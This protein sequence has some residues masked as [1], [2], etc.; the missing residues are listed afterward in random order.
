M[1][2]IFKK[3]ISTILIFEAKLVLKK[4]KPKIV[5]VT[6]SVG[7]TSTKDA[8]FAVLA[9]FKYVRKSEKSFNS[10]IGLP[11]TILGLE[12][13]WSNPFKWIRNILDGISLIV[14]KTDYPEWLVLEVGADRPGDI[15]KISEWLKSDIAVFTKF[16]KVPVHVEFFPTPKDVVEEKANL[17]RGLKKDG[18]LILNGDDEDATS[19]LERSKNHTLIYKVD[20]SADVSASNYKINYQEKNGIKSPIGISFKVEYKGNIVPVSIDGVLGRQQ[21]YPVLAGLTVAVAEDLNFVQAVE[22]LKN[23]E[24]PKGRMRIIEGIN[25]STIIDDTYNS[26]PV[27][28]NEAIFTLKSLEINSGSKKVAVLGDMM[29]LGKYSADEHKKVGEVL[30]E[31]CDV[32]ITVGLRANKYIAESAIASGMKKSQVLKF[33]NSVDAGKELAKILKPGDVVL[34]KGSQSIRMEKTVEE[35]LKNRE[36]A[37]KLLVRQEEEWLKR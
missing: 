12:N 27:A 29:E 4:Y 10:E 11:L 3:I 13:A 33:E 5:A 34:V 19:L 28:M 21:M 16:S 36:E 14:F 35:V 20:N 24:T 6:G 37:S 18:F 7:K 8:I 15:R 1:K 25:D 17:I 32:V 23:F 26:S 31:F 30:A 22:A 9:K 2:N